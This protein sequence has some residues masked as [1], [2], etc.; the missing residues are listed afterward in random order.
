M[1][2]FGLN[3]GI[4]GITNT[5]DALC[6]VCKR[7][8]ESLGHFRFDCPDFRE[9]FDSLWSNPCLKVTAR[10]PLDGEH[11][12]G[13]LMSLDQPCCSQAVF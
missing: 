3:G 2:N 4:P 7:D 11:I 12:I 8:T 5:H 10:N 6:F 1:G 13:F 9:H